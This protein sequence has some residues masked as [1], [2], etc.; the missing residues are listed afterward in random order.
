M[1]TPLP[2]AAPSNDG[3]I[4]HASHPG[5]ADQDW[6]KGAVE[7]D[8]PTAPSPKQDPDAPGLNDQGLPDDPV[9][10]GQ[11]RVGANADETQG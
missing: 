7:D 8:R 11:D 1:T 6:H 2:T 4:D 10:I 5:H 3:Q 9:A